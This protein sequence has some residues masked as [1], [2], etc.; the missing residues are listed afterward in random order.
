MLLFFPTGNMAVSKA[1]KKRQ[2]GARREADPM[3]R[4]AYLSKEVD[5]E[6][7][8]SEAGHGEDQAVQHDGSRQKP[9]QT[10]DLGEESGEESGEERDVDVR[11]EGRDERVDAEDYK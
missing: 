1:E 5:E 9:K 8:P 7:E 6:H 3:E 4:Q 10:I 11:S 2:Y